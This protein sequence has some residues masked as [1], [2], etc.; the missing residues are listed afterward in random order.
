MKAVLH[1]RAK[2][3]VVVEVVEAGTSA[4]LVNVSEEGV[5]LS[6]SGRVVC[7]VPKIASRR[8]GDRFPPALSVGCMFGPGRNPQVSRVLLPLRFSA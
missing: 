2:S 3:S 1:E 5:F 6:G 4:S 8:L 7:D